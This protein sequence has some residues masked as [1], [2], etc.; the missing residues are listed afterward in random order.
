MRTKM[1][2]RAKT[3]LVLVAACAAGLCGADIVV[4]DGETVDLAVADDAVQ[5]EPV[6][7]AA[8]AGRLEK[9]GAGVYTLATSNLASS[10]SAVVAVREGALNVAGGK[11]AEAAV[12]RGV[13]DRAALWLDASKADSRVEGTSA[14]NTG[15]ATWYDAREVQDAD[16]TWGTRYFCATARTSWLTNEVAEGVW[17]K[18]VLH[19]VAKTYEALP[20]C[21][22]LFFN[23]RLSGSWMGFCEPGTRAARTA[24]IG[25]IRHLFYSGYVEGAW[26]FPVGVMKGTTPF[27]HPQSPEG[28]LGGTWGSANS[29]SPGLFQG[30]SLLNGAVF[31]E[32]ATAVKAGPYVYEW[33]AGDVAGHF[34]NFF[35]DRDM[36]GPT[37]FRSGGDALGEVIAFTNRLTALEREQVA[38]YLL[39]KWSPAVPT[40]AVEV[41]TAKGAEVT[42]ADDAALTVTGAGTLRLAEAGRAQAYSMTEPFAGATR[43]EASATLV[44]GEPQLA[45]RAGDAYTVTRD[46]YDGLGFANAPDAAKAASGEARLDLAADVAVRVAS[47]PGTVRTLAV[48]GAGE[49][50]LAAPPPVGKGGAAVAGDVYATMPNADMEEWTGTGG[51]WIGNEGTTY[52]HWKMVSRVQGNHYFLNLPSLRESGHWTIDG[53]TKNFRWD[54]YP[55][56]GNVVMVL[57]QGCVVENTV[58]FP[59]DGDYELTF[60]TGGRMDGDGYPYAGG[61]V[62]VSLV[63]GAGAETP[64]GT[65]FG[66]VGVST[67]RQRFLVRGVKAGAYTFRL[68]HAV[69]TGDAHTILDDFR[70]RLVTDLPAET[71]A[72]PPNADFER[73]D[74]VWGGRYQRNVG[75]TVADWTLAQSEETGTEPDVC[76]VTRGMRN[77]GYRTGSTRGGV[78]LAFY[79]NAGSATSAA[80]TLPAGTWKLR[81]RKAAFYNTE[82]WDYR[83]NG[84]Q[85]NRAN[86]LAG[87]LLEGDDT[88]LSLGT[89]GGISGTKMTRATLPTAVTLT[90]PRTVRLRLRGTVA[91]ETAVVPCAVVDEL[92]FVRQDADGELVANGTFVDTSA[93]TLRSNRDTSTPDF[94]DNTAKSTAHIWD[95]CRSVTTGSGEKQLAYGN[96]Y[97]VGTLALDICQCGSAEQK[98][99][100]PAAGAYRLA[101]SARSRL[102]IYENAPPNRTWGGNQGQFYLVDAQGVTNEIF[103][104]P[105]LYA[106][107]FVFRSTL[108]NVPAAGT[109]TF[110]VRGLNGMPLPDGTTL[111]V[112]R[113]A[114]DV[115]FFVDQVSVKPA[116]DAALD[117]DEGLAVELRDTAKLRLDFT[118]TNEIARLRLGGVSVSGYVDATHPSGLVRG[119]GCLFIRPRG[120][121]FLLR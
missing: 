19:P 107:N 55:F 108:F 49:L 120:T 39:R 63:D 20:A 114:S 2:P 110:G 18:A 102:W 7:F 118:G 27:W 44:A 12:P 112:G 48:S 101:F 91:A 60:L 22:Y 75:N 1:L 4:D 81:L 9:S 80:F 88:V 32:A 89:L 66:Y 90:A 50:V 109:Y 10:A 68:D 40:P 57:K 119:T 42:V 106:S 29:A 111:Q 56:Q 17:E 41:R 59:V 62:K 99:T 71:V 35:N 79:G 8:E 76:L 16:G 30:R 52:F 96:T 21:T 86:G 121:V 11:P 115:E 47:L 95:P 6:W 33:D 15:V 25:E 53:G 61:W 93:W 105:S 82:G 46:L 116:A 28:T 113:T 98:L 117:L 67:R 36:W 26:G 83:W 23:G 100:F 103:R 45:L 70:F 94:A 43:V 69:G 84:R 34:G 65:A 92:E 38:N 37:Y 104:T 87:E 54:D 13:L 73:V 85:V 77:V 24:N 72:Y 14:L 31:D 51:T 3:L 58:T 78:Q 97:G 5:T 64:V 74:L